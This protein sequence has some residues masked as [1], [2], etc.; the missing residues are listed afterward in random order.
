MS[1]LNLEVKRSN[2]KNYRPLLYWRSCKPFIE[3][4]RA[5]LVHRPRSITTHKSHGAIG[6]THI[7][8]T[9]YCGSGAC[10]VGSNISF[11]NN[12]PDG[13]ILCHRCEAGAVKLGLPSSSEICGRH[14]HVGGAKG[15]IFC[16]D[17]SNEDEK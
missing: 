11:L 15:V 6:G 13:Q 9:Y 1:M 7:A 10:G 2:N 14:V 12:V 3:N 4:S 5:M 8:M 17:G 16:C